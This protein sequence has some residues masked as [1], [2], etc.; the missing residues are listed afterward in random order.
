MT[1]SRLRIAAVDGPFITSPDA[2]RRTPFNAGRMAIHDPSGRGEYHQVYQ[3]FG[4]PDA[5]NAH[6]LDIA[7]SSGLK[8]HVD[9]NGQTANVTWSRD[10]PEGEAKHSGILLKRGHNVLRGR[11]FPDTR[12]FVQKG[13]SL[14]P[15]PNNAEAVH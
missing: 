2:E 4:Q 11:M 8:A 12:Y 7:Q 1:F 13:K 3:N 15:Q 5:F 6:V 10:L 14:M 9:H